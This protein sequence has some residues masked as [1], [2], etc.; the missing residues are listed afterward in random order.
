MLSGDKCCL[1]V[2][3]LSS[4]LLVVTCFVI[5]TEGSRFVFLLSYCQDKLCQIHKVGIGIVR[6]ALEPSREDAIFIWYG[7]CPYL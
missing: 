4:L 5:Q 2:T 3:L 1:I 7:F 6:N